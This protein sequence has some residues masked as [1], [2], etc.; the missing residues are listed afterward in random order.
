MGICTTRATGTV[1]A[2]PRDQRHISV[3]LTGAANASLYA[4]SFWRHAQVTT[5]DCLKVLRAQPSGRAT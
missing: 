4:A 3:L 5:N 2:T 1:A